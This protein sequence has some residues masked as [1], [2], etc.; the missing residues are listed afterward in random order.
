[1]CAHVMNHYAEIVGDSVLLRYRSTWSS[2]T[3]NSNKYEHIKE[4]LAYAYY[5][6]S[7]TT[8]Y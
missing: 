3:W 5:V 7:Y 6:L 8:S 2:Q 1:M 4:K